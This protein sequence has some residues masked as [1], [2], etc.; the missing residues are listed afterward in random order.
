MDPNDIQLH[1]TVHESLPPPKMLKRIKVLSDT[2]EIVDGISYEQSV[3][4]YKR[5]LNPEPNI[6]IYEEMARVYNEFCKNRC[7]TQPERMDVY[8][9]VLLRSMFPGNE[10]LKRASLSTVSEKEAN[11]ILADYKLKAEPIPVIQK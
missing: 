10:A 6:V 7:A 9:L 3:G 2:F 4:L 11:Q 8:R 5:D 1:P